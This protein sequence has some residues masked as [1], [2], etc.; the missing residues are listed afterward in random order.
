MDLDTAV[1][2]SEGFADFMWGIASIIFWGTILH[3]NSKSKQED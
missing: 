2:I 1:K 3:Y